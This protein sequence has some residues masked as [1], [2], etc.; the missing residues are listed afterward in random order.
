MAASCRT[1]WP[2]LLG[3]PALTSLSRCIELSA[4]TYLDTSFEEGMSLSFSYFTLQGLIRHSEVLERDVAVNGEASDALQRM[5][6][7]SMS[8]GEVRECSATC[9]CGL[10]LLGGHAYALTTAVTAQLTGLHRTLVD[11]LIAGG[12]PCLQRPCRSR[13]AAGAVQV[14]VTTNHLIRLSCACIGT[15]SADVALTMR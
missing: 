14:T 3:W 4:S 11:G 6:S 9:G 7:R 2:S 12:G 13:L 1:R 15:M 10:R 8:L 5:L